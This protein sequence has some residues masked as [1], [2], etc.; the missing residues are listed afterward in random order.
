M[1]ETNTHSSNTKSDYLLLFR[2][3]AW[4][5]GLPQE[6]IQQMVT[7]WM[8]WFE[9]NKAAGKVLGGHSLEQSGK[10][11]TGRNGSHVADGP[12]TESKE[13]IAGYFYLQ[14]SG[15]DEALEIAKQCPG[16]EYGMSV[17]VRPVD[18]QCRAS[19]LREQLSTTETANA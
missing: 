5:Q 2:G 8:A 17:E 10:L 19:R 6:K 13:A 3:T 15:L 4:D 7:N 12:F 11:V 14:V 18:G 9:E 1:S 16:L